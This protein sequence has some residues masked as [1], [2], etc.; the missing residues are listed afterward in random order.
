MYHGN[1]IRRIAI[2]CLLLAC[3]LPAQ[4]KDRNAPRGESGKFDYYL[5]DL[6]W[7][8]GFCNSPAGQ[9]DHVQ[10][11]GTKQFAFVLH[12]LWPQFERGYPQ[13]C[14]TDQTLS[15]NVADKMLDI[16]PS[17][18]LIAHEWEKHGVCSGMNA[19]QYFDTAR[20]AFN[21]VR[22]PSRFQSP[23]QAQTLPADD[24]RN[25]FVRANPSMPPSA[26]VVQCSGNGRFL[27]EMQICLTRDLKA[28]AC[29]SDVS[30]RACKSSEVIV[31][32]LR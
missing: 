7:S 9:R 8:P 13:F 30:R 24:I 10:C 3:A 12:G 28:R 14:V 22:I 29:S 6:S 32:P 2:L 4:R 15:K 31:Q 1:M 5:L 17:S 11:G 25:E 26:F 23:K 19:A 21:S 18:R 27:S 20:K 16:M